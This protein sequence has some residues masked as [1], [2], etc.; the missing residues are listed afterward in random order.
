MK[1][2]YKFILIIFAITLIFTHNYTY[3]SMA[4][5]TDE[6]AD[7]V[8]I[9]EQKEWKKEQEERINKSSNNYLKSLSIDKY[10]ITPEFDKQTINYEI[11]QEITE[12]SIKINVE[13]DDENASVSGD[14]EIILNSGENNL[15]IDVT[16]QNGTVRTYFIKITKKT[17]SDIKLKAL[18]IMA[19][20]NTNIEVLP[21]F[22]ENIFEYSCT[23]ENYVNEISVYPESNTENVKIDIK[24]NKELKEGLNEVLIELSID[25]EKKVIYKIN[26]NKKQ[27]TEN[28][29][30]SINYKTICISFSAITLII[31]LICI[32]IIIKRRKD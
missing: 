13:T 12:N 6:E 32:F 11:K 27:T 9:Q 20:D 10:D 18:K 25:N 24:G 14:G 3:A 23:V 1:K 28:Q 31:I 26:V 29:H 30:N 8:L 7:A 22:N 17:Y 16:A 4:D 2:I 21:D 15:R 5:F 19:D